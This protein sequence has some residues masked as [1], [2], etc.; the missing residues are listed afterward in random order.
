MIE[1][2]ER[3]LPTYSP[4][5]SKKAEEQLRRLGVDVITNAIVPKIQFGDV[6]VG[7]LG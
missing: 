5:L 6:I 2:K 3:V 4:D 7:T 1:G